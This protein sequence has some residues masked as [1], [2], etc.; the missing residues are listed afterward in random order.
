V[1][2][3]A[4]VSLAALPEKDESEPR[5]RQAVEEALEPLGGLRAFVSPGAKVLLKPNQTLFL[6]HESGSTTS[7]P[8]MRVLIR[9]CRELDAKE[10]WVGEA[11]GHAQKSRNVMQNTGMTSGVKKAEALVAYFDEVAN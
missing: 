5:L 8:L 6:P 1:T 7:P 10:V 2:D 4:R 9:L 3:Q 11:S